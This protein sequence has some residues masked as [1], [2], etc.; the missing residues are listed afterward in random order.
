MLQTIPSNKASTNRVRTRRLQWQQ[1]HI[2]RNSNPVSH[3]RSEAACVNG[4]DY[5]LTAQAFATRNLMVHT[6]YLI[7][8]SARP[9]E[10]RPFGTQDALTGGVHQLPSPVDLWGTQAL[11]IWIHCLQ[12]L[13]HR[14]NVG[15][16]FV[17]SCE[18][19]LYTFCCFQQLHVDVKGLG[20]GSTLRNLPAA[21]EDRAKSVQSF[22][23]PDKNDD[24]D[25]LP[26]ML[27]ERSA[28]AANALCSHPMALVSG[29]SIERP[30]SVFI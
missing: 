26:H 17:C 28:I 27:K 25:C 5:V 21:S 19:T 13:C 24:N 16:V 8:G 18:P 6:Y 10:W 14:F 9:Q 2:L 4:S 15:L 11:R 23:I 30:T 1:Q 20:V 29:L 22:Y 12:S 3:R 7:D